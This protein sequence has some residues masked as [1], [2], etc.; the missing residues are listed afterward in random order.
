M[1]SSPSS[2]P[3]NSSMVKRGIR[4]MLGSG[5]RRRPGSPPARR[6]ARDAHRQHAG[7]V[8]QLARH[9]HRHVAD[10][11]RPGTAAFQSWTALKCG[12][13]NSASQ[14]WTICVTRGGVEFGHQRCSHCGCVWR[15]RPRALRWRRAWPSTGR[16]TGAPL[17]PGAGAPAGAAERTACRASASDEA[18]LPSRCS[19]KYATAATR[20]RRR[21][22]ARAGRTRRGGIE[23]AAAEQQV[24]GRRL[25]DAKRQQHRGRRR[26]DAQLHLGL[27]ELG[28]RRGEVAWPAKA[29]SRPPPGHWPCRPGRA[30]EVDHRQDQLC[31]Q[32]SICAHCAGRC[33]STLAPS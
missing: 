8:D 29:T 1:P 20:G 12:S 6:A 21:R 15:G 22:P 25:V 32:A 31:S 4:R 3:V 14:R 13:S 26:E 24:F 30:R 17:R 7:G 11:A 33:S 28:I 16:G 5:S 9:V 10:G 19:M 23:R 18:L 2:R 27:A